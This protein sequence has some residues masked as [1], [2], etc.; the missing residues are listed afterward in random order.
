M[1]R[2]ARGGRR[3]RDIAT[4]VALAAIA[5]LLAACSELP[6]RPAPTYWNIAAV[7]AGFP[8][9]VR[10]AD[11]A[12]TFDARAPQLVRRVVDAAG[13]RPVNVLALSGG[14]AGSA[15]GAGA[16]VGWTR[17]GNR[18][19]FQIVTGVSAGA[20]LAPF[21]FLGEAWDGPLE[22]AFSGRRTAH[23]LQRRWALS[24]LH[25]SLYRGEPLVEL[26]DH[27]VTDE[28]LGAIARKAGDG[29]MLLVATTDLDQQRTVIWN[30]G[31]VASVGGE[32]ARRLFRDIIVASASIPGVFPPVLI[33]VEQSGEEFDELHV[34]GGTT[35]P[36]FIA[37]EI[38]NV[39]PDRLTPL[40][41][42]NVYAIV[43]GQLGVP[44]E[45]V[46]SGTIAVVKRSVSAV[47]QSSSRLA[48]EVTEALTQ[49]NGMHF[50]LTA[51]PSGYPYHGPLDTTPS[52][53]RELFDFGTACAATGQLWRT[54]SSLL[55]AADAD[56]A[57]KTGAGSACPAPAASL[58][59]DTGQA[60]GDSP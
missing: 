19:D 27:Y 39:V 22:E 25:S 42:A 8:D 16:L 3:T 21:A 40:R 52:A 1:T 23:L 28:L 37:P 13:G 51:I 34:D 43:N 50:L 46:A 31:V 44:A 11:R 59:V 24:W 26:V 33:R 5:G 32:R 10:A 6:R 14:G 9:T 48:V 17:R 7:P 54:A 45:T 56:P 57:L 49:R 35:A 18:P 36:I 55:L 38:V 4:V 12:E 20:L 41:G 58:V 2:S 53:M 15:F 60:S 47:L 29:G 30:L